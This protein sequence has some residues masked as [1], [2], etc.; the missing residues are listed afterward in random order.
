[1]FKKQKVL[2]EDGKPIRIQLTIIIMS[3]TTTYDNKQQSSA[4]KRPSKLTQ[5]FI[6]HINQQ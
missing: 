6:V 3:A 1:M 4:V 2:M 5:T